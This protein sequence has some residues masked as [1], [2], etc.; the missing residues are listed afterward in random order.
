ADVHVLVTREGTGSGG[1]AQTIDIIGLG[2]FD[3]LN[4]STVFNTPANTTEAEERNGFL[5]TL[6][7]ALVPY[8][9]QTSMRDR[10]FVDIAP[11]EEDAVD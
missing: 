11:S 3:G 4:F 2:V 9:M 7:A 5:Q 8:L 6:E 10:L 1:E